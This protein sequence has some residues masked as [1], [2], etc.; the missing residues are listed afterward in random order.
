MV[1]QIEIEAK[2][3]VA[4]LGEFGKRLEQVAG[5]LQ[6]RVIQRDFYYDRAVEPLQGAGSGLRLRQETDHSKREKNVLC[7]K[8]P[9]NHS[10]SLKEREEIEFEVRDT[11]KV[12]D[13]L[14][15]LG[16]D[17][18]LTFEKHRTVWLL[19]ECVV[20]LDQV[21]ELGDYIEI[22]G[23]SEQAIDDAASKL[24]LEGYTHIHSNYAKLLTKHLQEQ[25]GH[26]HRREVLLDRS[27]FDLEI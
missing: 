24:G 16:Y 5:R 13:F 15:A 6:S 3:K 1:M 4:D 10:G 17:L 7:F 14:H 11:R 27:A 8:G 22:E 20:C 25:E 21:V 12:Q 2:I 19:D 9:V 26:S 18:C 23:P